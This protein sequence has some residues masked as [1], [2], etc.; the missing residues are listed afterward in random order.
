MK[1]VDKNEQV[2]VTYKAHDSKQTEKP[3]ITLLN[4]DGTK[5]DVGYMDHVEDGLYTFQF[6]APAK[7]TY[8]VAVV[9]KAMGTIVVGVPKVTKIFYYDENPRSTL[10]EFR[11]PN[12]L[13]VLQKG[14]MH[15]IGNSLYVITTTLDGSVQLIAGTR[16][17][18]TI[19]L[20]FRAENLPAG[21]MRIMAEYN[22]SDMAVFER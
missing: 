7:D 19:M 10:Y 21:P 12:S 22:K 11:D 16:E 17:G 15:S 5:F 14:E 18:A 2:T 6:V 9:G 3:E 20:P 8:M 1:F 4:H 13:T